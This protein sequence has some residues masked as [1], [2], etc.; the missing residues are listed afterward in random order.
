MKQN[1]IYMISAALLIAACGGGGGGGEQVAGIDGRGAPSAVGVVSLGTI[2]GFGS[3]IVNGQTFNTSSATF[4]IDG[5]QGTQSDLSVGDVVLIEGTITNGGAPVASNVTFDDAVEG[6]I[7]GIDLAAQT[8][9]VLGQL[10]RVDAA[11]SFDDDISP[12]SLEG[13]SVDEVVEVSGFL[14]ADGSIGATRIERKAPGG[15]LELTGTVSNAGATTFEINGFV[16]DY[17]AAMLSSF[18]NG[19][20]ENGQRVEAKGNSLV[21]GELVATEVEFKGGQF[22]DDGDEAEVEGYITVFNSAS[23]FAVEGVR[24]TTNAQ[25]TYENGTSGELALNRKVEV[26][27]EINA[28]GV[29]V[30]ESVE[31]K[32]TGELRIESLVEDVQAN[33][34]TVL[35]ITIAV[36]AATRFE[37]DSDAD[38]EI[39]NL[40]NVAIGDYV[41]IRGYDDGGTVTAT[42]LERDE[43]GGDVALRGFVDSIAEPNFVI[44]DVTIAT[45]AGTSFTDNDGVTD[46][47]AGQFF[48]QAAGRLVEA[49]GTLNGGIIEADEV[50]FEN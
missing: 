1:P 18:P 40:S 50:E 38:L 7:S 3:V 12:K 46:L 33:Q 19:A 8:L 37:D 21:N 27:G 36:N 25:T 26:E 6:P 17:G 28:S 35:G 39:F 5:Q 4:T 43:F 48:G 10:V 45:D 15:K 24:V 42:L 13:L 9:T 16:V 14:L 44:L 22:G 30:A 34:L 49:S 47:T 20:P 29:L 2:T 32:P 11:T 41:E 23:D 31:F